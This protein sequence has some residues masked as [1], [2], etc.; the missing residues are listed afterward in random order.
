M[1][2]SVYIATSLD[3]FIARENG[4]LDWLIQASANV[5][6]DED[7]GYNAF[8][9]TV[10]VLVMGRNTYE[11]VLSFGVDWPYE[12]HVIVLSRRELEVP[13]ALYGK[14][15]H[16]SEAPNVLVAR[17]KRQGVKRI[18]LDGGITVQRFL[19][20]GLVDDLCITVI[21]ILLGCGKSLFNQSDRDVSATKLKLIESKAYDFGFVQSHYE[22]VR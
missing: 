5:P 6:K 21:P 10:D 17:L 12:K 22:V 3:G 13:E 2:V 8:M 11:K 18:Y 9:D 7:C 4:D 19:N 15:S 14:V 16:S 1:Q 20:A